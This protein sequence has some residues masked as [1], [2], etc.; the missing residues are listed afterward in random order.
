MT[1]EV[2][3]MYELLKI[4]EFQIDTILGLLL[5]FILVRSTQI[6]PL[7][8]FIFGLLAF[9]ITGYLYAKLQDLMELEHPKIK[10]IREHPKYQTIPMY[11]ELALSTALLLII[12]SVL[13]E[14]L[15]FLYVPMVFVYGLLPFYCCR[16]LWLYKKVMSLT[17]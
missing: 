15:P 5:G 3:T 8:C 6:D 16:C 2:I 9:G 7:V 17:Q 4:R 1:N 13:V 14:F 12:E 10:F 11:F